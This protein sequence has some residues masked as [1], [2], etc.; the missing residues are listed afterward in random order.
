MRR[1]A[2]RQRERAQ[3]RPGDEAA[4]PGA[5]LPGVRHVASS[6]EAAPKTAAR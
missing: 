1:R 2:G 5:G 4:L 3:R 6:T